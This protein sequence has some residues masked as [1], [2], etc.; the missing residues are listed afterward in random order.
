[1]SAMNEYAWKTSAAVLS[2]TFP[3]DLRAIKDQVLRLY[4]FDAKRIRIYYASAD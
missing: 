4:I 3:N 1:M 2:K